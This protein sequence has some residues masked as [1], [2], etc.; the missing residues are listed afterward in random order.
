MKKSIIAVCSIIG[1]AAV[2]TAT[3]VILQRVN[4]PQ[5]QPATSSAQTL[6][7]EALIE[8]IRTASLSSLEV[9]P[10]GSTDLRV[11]AQPS[12][13]SFAV[14]AS[15]PYGLL[16]SAASDARGLEP[17]VAMQDIGSLLR[18]RGLDKQSGNATTAN[19][20]GDKA[21]CSVQIQT[22]GR[23]VVSVAC[24]D[25]DEQ[26]NEYEAVQK[27]L[28]VYAQ[29]PSAVPLK[30][31]EIVSA[32]RTT[33]QRGAIEGAVLAVTYKKENATKG[34]A[35]L[36][37]AQDGVWEYVANV[38]EGENTGRASVSESARSAITDSKWNGVL[39]GLVGV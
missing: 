17:D 14:V 1:F 19:Y 5:V 31:E 33:S 35:L 26:K 18:G 8:A 13:T 29:T 7:A 38:G 16:Y 24:V 25:V 30:A 28:T 22:E 20:Q 15:T 6:G 27:L 23:R 21:A 11:N 32:E 36:F 3:I 9:E 12:G 37:G 39:A 2:M 4:A 34:M 10:A